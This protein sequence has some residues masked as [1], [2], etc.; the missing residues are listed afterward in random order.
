[1][2]R[3]GT[4]QSTVAP[5]TMG[6]IK[7]DPF[8]TSYGDASIGSTFAN[9]S[10]ADN[11]FTYRSPKYAGFQFGA[12]YSLNVDEE[13]DTPDTDPLG[14]RNRAI[15]LA[16]TYTNDR[17]FLSL[18]FSQLNF[19]NQDGY[20]DART[21]A[22]GGT[23]NLTDT[24]KLFAGVQYQSDWRS[25]AGM[26]AASTSSYGLD[27]WSYLLGATQTFGPHK[28]IADVQ[29]FNGEMSND[30]SKDA[31]RTILAAAYEYY[32]SKTL[33]GYCAATYSDVSGALGE[34]N[35]NLD[36]YMLMIGLDKHF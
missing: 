1:M 29:Y 9:S 30:S 35:A 7:F 4:V 15:A 11:A 14:D 3:M 16:T 18:T 26:K 6:L 25:A 5:F 34:D 2:G 24:T 21:Y 33:I 32:F 36:R 28:I 27:G 20:K 10:R 17:M 8:G 22:L 19:S 31:K 13:A 23:Y 12:T